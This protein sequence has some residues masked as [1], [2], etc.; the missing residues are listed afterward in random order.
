MLDINPMLKS[1]IESLLFISD[2]PLSQKELAKLLDAE[3][4]EVGAVLENLALEYNSRQ[5]SGIRIITEAGRY[6]MTTTPGNSKIVGKFLKSEITG[7]LTKPSLETLAI[8]SYRGPISKAELDQ[9]RGVNCALILRNLMIKGLIEEIEEKGQKLYN[10]SFDFLRHLG[11]KNKK[12][13]PDYDRLS[14]MKLESLT[15]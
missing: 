13:L 12:E 9:I 15:Q 14:K 5:T 2:R 4:K 3:E 7:E 1:L 11:I 10:I 6:Q 8:I